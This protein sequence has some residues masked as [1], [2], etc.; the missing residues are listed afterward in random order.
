M[1]ILDFDQGLPVDV[2]F[3]PA[4]SPP[5]QN[6]EKN[7]YHHQDV[8]EYW[9]TSSS[10]YDQLKLATA[11]RKLPSG[12]IRAKGVIS[13]VDSTGQPA[14]VLVTSVAGRTEFM[15]WTGKREADEATTGIIFLGMKFQEEQVNQLM[16][17]A[18][19]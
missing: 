15:S 4:L 9:F 10:Q 1:Q 7:E 6:Q 8:T 13:V 3:E 2:L 12:V 14:Q 18:Q 11:F 19:I 16:E 17:S 5:A